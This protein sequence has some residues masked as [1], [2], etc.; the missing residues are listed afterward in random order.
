M[1]RCDY[2]RGTVECRGDGYLWDA[3]KDGYDPRDHSDPCPGCNTEQYLMSAKENAESTSS[4]ATLWGSGT[5][6]DLW[7]AGVRIAR[8]ANPEATKK[9][10]ASIGPVNAAVDDEDAEDSYAVCICNQ[11][12]Q[13]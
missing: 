8:E 2:Q 12:G 9:A 11:E 1:S 4:W 10:L 3:D 7:A 5:G 13:G 6:V